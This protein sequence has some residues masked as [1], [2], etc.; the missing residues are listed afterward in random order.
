MVQNPLYLQKVSVEGVQR[1][2]HLENE[3]GREGGIT[4]EKDDEI[5]HCCSCYSLHLLDDNDKRGFGSWAVFLINPGQLVKIKYHLLTN[6]QMNGKG[7]MIGNEE[8][9]PS[10]TSRNVSI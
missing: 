7:Y 1:C 4:R 2:G 6:F 3:D 8:M 10:S 5:P 9:S